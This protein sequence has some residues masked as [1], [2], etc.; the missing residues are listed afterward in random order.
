MRY[1]YLWRWVL[2]EAKK[3]GH[4]IRSA[5]EEMSWELVIDDDGKL[6]WY[7]LSSNVL[8]GD[9]A[10]AIEWH[11]KAKRQEILSWLESLKKNKT[12]PVEPGSWQNEEKEATT[13]FRLLRKGKGRVLEDEFVR[14]YVLGKDRVILEPRR[15][16]KGQWRIKMSGKPASPRT[17]SYIFPPSLRK[18]FE[19]D[20]KTEAPPNISGSFQPWMRVEKAEDGTY[21]IYGMR[22]MAEGVWNGVPITKE[23][24]ARIVQAFHMLKDTLRVPLKLEHSEK[25]ASEL[26]PALGWVKDLRIEDG[27]LVADLIKVP[28]E[29]V[30]LIKRGHYIHVSPEIAEYLSGFQ[31]VLIGVALI[32]GNQPAILSL[33]S[34][35]QLYSSEEQVSAIK[36]PTPIS[37][38]QRQ[39]KEDE[40]AN[41]KVT[42]QPGNQTREPE[43]EPQVRSEA[44]ALEILNKISPLAGS[45]LFERKAA[46]LRFERP[47][48]EEAKS[49]MQKYID[50]LKMK[51][52]PTQMAKEMLELMPEVT[53][54]KV[55]LIPEYSREL[56]SVRIDVLRERAQLPERCEEVVKE[57]EEF[58]E[59]HK[60]DLE[61]DERKAWENILETAKK[62]MGS[63]TVE[64]AKKKEKKE[65]EEVPP[66][67]EYPKYPSYPKYPKYPKAGPGAE[68]SY[69]QK[70]PTKEEEYP[71]KKP[72]K[73][74]EYPQQPPNVT[75][76]EM[77][78]QLKQKATEAIVA[79]VDALR[80]A[81]MDDLQ[82]EKLKQL[83]FEL[84]PHIKPDLDRARVKSLI[85]ELLSTKTPSPRFSTLTVPQGPGINREELVNLLLRR[86]RKEEE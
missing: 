12:V 22:I 41:K 15:G 84:D 47:K 77:Q 55:E 70:K 79:R 4:T 67:E 24:M 45:L 30:S 10:F 44:S 17:F 13:Y 28:E 2:G 49:K 57:I 25:F 40:M 14:R 69:P 64:D 9:K 31:D 38:L 65:S 58:L 63:I 34:L 11:P 18:T 83:L 76:R 8:K 72:T 32:G 73:E 16:V 35:I 62:N 1:W 60:D 52:Y 78:L 20:T 29:I 27:F 21:R 51:G 59:M 81:G 50:T 33:P 6:I 39:E 37:A 54:E 43:K 66:T 19:S 5:P 85:F 86:Q 71:E 48:T 42:A 61:E 46:F 56:W 74:E 3:R 7:R 53:D 68:E 23:R 75:V 26:N 80:A 82:A 36:V